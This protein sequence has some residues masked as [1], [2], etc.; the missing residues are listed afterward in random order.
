MRK[1]FFYCTSY[2]FTLLEFLITLALVLILASLGIPYGSDWLAQARAEMVIHRLH[3]AVS[4][5]RGLA[6][7]QGKI[8]TL[9]PSH[10]GQQ[11]SKDWS[12]GYM[13]FI[14]EF[15]DQRPHSPQHILRIFEGVAS[16]EQLLF[17]GFASND[18]LRL[19]PFTDVYQQ[20]GTFIYCPQSD[21]RRFARALIVSTT[22][23]ARHEVYSP[24]CKGGEYHYFSINLI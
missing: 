6:L 11:C 15:N 9:C 7:A 10:N 5:A 12:Q 3:A 22:G 20:N 23:R 1:R 18:Y 14:D 19:Q 16:G 2:G 4:Y 8:I 21:P 13:V 17:T 24:L